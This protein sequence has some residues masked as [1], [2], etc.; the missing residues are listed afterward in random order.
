MPA[1]LPRRPP[2]ANTAPSLDV[3]DR[4]P[5]EVDRLVI[6]I[7]QQ[8]EREE[9]DQAVQTLFSLALDQVRFAIGSRRAVLLD[10]AGADVKSESKLDSKSEAGHQGRGGVAAARRHF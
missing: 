3:L 4:M 8:T 10:Q 6:A 2:L 9:Y 1:R 7:I 5:S